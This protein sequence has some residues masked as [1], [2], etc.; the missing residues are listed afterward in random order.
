MGAIFAIKMIRL[1]KPK[2]AD[3]MDQFWAKLL[4]KGAINKNSFYGF[5]C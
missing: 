2:G 4:W 5:W 1:K 3:F